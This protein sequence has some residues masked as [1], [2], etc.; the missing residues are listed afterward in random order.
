MS[1][2]PITRSPS[3]QFENNSLDVLRNVIVFGETGAGKSSVV[4]MLKGDKEAP[5]SNGTAGQ[6]SR[7]PSLKGWFPNLPFRIFDTVGLNEGT[8]GTVALEVA[9]ERLFGLI[10][11]LD[12]GV[13]LLVYVMHAPHVKDTVQKN[14][15][16]F[17]ELFFQ[18]RVPV[19]IVITGLEN[20]DDMDVWW[21]QNW[22]PFRDN[23]MIF[24]GY[25]CITATKG[26]YKNG[27]HMFEEKY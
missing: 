25:A 2:S 11:N 23:G 22:G 15:K 3:T 17:S 7:T 18:G 21:D 10:Q 1:L 26:K 27:G 24:S 20:E 13:N 14:Y 5:M 12:H 16:M 19:V 4:N 9:V 6:T 8:A